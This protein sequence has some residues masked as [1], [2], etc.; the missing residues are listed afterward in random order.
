MSATLLDL[1]RAARTSGEL[2]DTL[3]PNGAPQ[4]LDEAYAVASALAEGR[5]AIGGWKIGAT[6]ARGQTLLGLTEPFFGRI[7]S[8]TIHSQP[9]HVN[10][11]APFAI[12]PEIAFIME[13]DLPA[14]ARAYTLEEVMDA[15]EAIAPALEI[16]RP[17]Y[18]R[19]FDAGGLAL[20]ADNGVNAGAC[21]GERHREWRSLDLANITVSIAAD[22]GQPFQGNSAAVLGNPLNALMWLANALPRR[23]HRLAAGQIV[24]SGAMTPPIDLAAG[25]RIRAYFPGLGEVALES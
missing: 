13:R 10:G 11:P 25:G 2:I 19:P 14:R 23:G 21:M 5:G 3:P 9:A 8:E 15:I 18:R 12:E 4:T 17:S 7:F 24:L 22:A 1:L 6:A 20:I 16:N